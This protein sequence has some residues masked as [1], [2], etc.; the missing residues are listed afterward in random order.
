VLTGIQSVMVTLQQFASKLSAGQ[1]Y[2]SQKAK[3]G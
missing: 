1:P 2:E 3:V